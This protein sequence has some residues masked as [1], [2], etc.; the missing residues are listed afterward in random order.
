MVRAR[1]RSTAGA[2]RRAV[3]VHGAFRDEITYPSQRPAHLFSEAGFETH[4]V[5]EGRPHRE[6]RDGVTIWYEPSTLHIARRIFGLAPA[7]TFVESTMPGALTVP[8]SRRVW[9]R[10]PPTA[11][12]P[13]KQRVV[14]AAVGRADVVSF[15]NPHARDQWSGPIRRDVDLQYPFD[16]AFWSRPVRRDPAWWIARESTVPD[17]PVYVVIANLVGIK[18]IPELV[19]WIS[20][21]LIDRPAARLVI[22][23]REY[24]PGEESRIRSAAAETGVAPQVE[25]VGWLPR[26]DIAQLLSWASASLINSVS[27]TQCLAVYESLAASVPCVVRDIPQLTSAF[28]E[29]ERFTDPGSLSAAL[30]RVDSEP[31]LGPTMRAS[32]AP[33]L[34]RSSIEVHDRVFLRTLEELALHA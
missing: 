6:A 16:H 15:T 3:M 10:N 11:G 21:H 9:I 1:S 26:A 30:D 34:E 27:E 20:G 8:I 32:A 28:P 22:V 2:R 29:I 31:R 17:G 5:G 25:L 14:D 23:G 24:E 4:V 18:R 19:R 33:L 7:V 12:S 13:L